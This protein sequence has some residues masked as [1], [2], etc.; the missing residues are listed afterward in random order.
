LSDG[1]FRQLAISGDFFCFPKEGISL[2][3]S[4]L[5]E[6]P[7]GAAIRTLSE[8]YALDGVET[9]GIDIEDW[10]TVLRK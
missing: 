3:E 4:M 9:P 6:S 8:F 1:R 2:I 7:V 10:L 5:E